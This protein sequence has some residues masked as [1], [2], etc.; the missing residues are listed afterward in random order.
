MVALINSDVFRR[1]IF[2][3]EVFLYSVSAS[4]LSGMLDLLDWVYRDSAVQV[5]HVQP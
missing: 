4:V 5:A 1:F 2:S 3:H